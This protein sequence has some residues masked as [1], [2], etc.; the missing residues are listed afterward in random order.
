M[1]EAV[2]PLLFSMA[3]SSRKAL[4]AGLIFITA[5]ALPLLQHRLDAERARSRPVEAD[6]TVPSAPYL[7]RLSLGY[8]LVVADFYWLRAT[9]YIGDDT[10]VMRDSP[11]LYRLV[12]LVTDLDPT[13]LV[14]YEAGA[15]AL[16]FLAGRV[17]ESNAILKKGWREYPERWRFPFTLGF[18][19]FYFNEAYAVAARYLEQAAILPNRPDFLPLLVTRLY[20][21]AHDPETALGFLA[22][23]YETTKD[24]RMRA[25]LEE[26]IKDLLLERDFLLFGRAIEV[27]RHRVG[28]SPERL[29]QLVEAG[30]LQ[31]LPLEP[32]GGRYELDAET[33]EVRSTTVRPRLRLYRPP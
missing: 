8:A 29:E 15:I 17:D 32:F 1:A 12:D 20:A 19:A 13:F 25:K 23:V 22:R 21:Q 33:G 14:P 4:L 5:A 24:E 27:Y 2:P 10:V 30:L 26:R 3:S 18:N 16:S 9:L 31:A 11:F 28:S 6:L 7:K